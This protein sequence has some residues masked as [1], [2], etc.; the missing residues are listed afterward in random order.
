MLQAIKLPFV[1]HAVVETIAA[2]TFIFRPETQLPNPSL[3]ARLV[4]Q[5]FGGLL[6]STSLVAA[7]VASQP[8]SDQTTRLVGASLAFWHLWPCYRAVVRISQGSGEEGPEVKTL[9]G[10]PVHLGV[11]LVL[12]FMFTGSALSS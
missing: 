1:L 7:A 11:H 9:G 4:L 5:S 10:P 2:V 8:V 6:L 3:D 12:L